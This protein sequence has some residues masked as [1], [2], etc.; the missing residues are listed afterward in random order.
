MN[1]ALQVS[2]ISQTCAPHV[3]AFATRQQ[4]GPKKPSKGM[5]LPIVQ[6]TVEAHIHAGTASPVQEQCVRQKT[7]FLFF[8]RNGP[9]GGR[10]AP[11]PKKKHVCRTPRH[12]GNTIPDPGVA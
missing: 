10:G 8:R 4:A 5:S 12:L 7:L 9:Q 1:I 11:F 3:S 6:N 2:P